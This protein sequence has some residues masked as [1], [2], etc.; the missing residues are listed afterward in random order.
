MPTAW[1]WLDVH[2]DNF[3]ENISVTNGKTYASCAAIPTAAATMYAPTANA[4]TVAVIAGSSSIN[5]GASCANVRSFTQHDL[6][7]AIEQMNP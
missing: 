6:K 4:K 2:V 7:A 5:T 3:T 1:Q